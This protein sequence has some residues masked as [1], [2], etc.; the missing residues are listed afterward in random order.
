MLQDLDSLAERIRK[1]VQAA[2]QLQA[3]RG[4]LQARVRQLEQECNALK[5]Q[6]IRE[7]D[8]FTRMS[9]RVAHHDHELQSVRDEALAARAALEDQVRGQKGQ[10]DALRERLEHA[11]SDRDKLRQVAQ[12]AQEQID[13]ILERLPGAE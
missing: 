4:T 6:Q 5:D 11:E 10:S 3:E 13:L 9:E 12:S 1:L 7:Q 2:R 8:E